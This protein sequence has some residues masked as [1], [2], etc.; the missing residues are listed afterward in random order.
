MSDHIFI[1]YSSADASDFAI[2]LTLELQSRT[3]MF[4][5]WLDK[6]E[7][8]PGRDWD[9]QIVEGIRDCRALAFI[10]TRDSVEDHSVCKQEWTRALK[11][12]KPIVP[13]RLQRD[14]EMPFRLEPRQFIDFS[15]DFDMALAKLQKYLGWLDSPEGELQ[16][17][18]DRLADANRDLRRASNEDRLRIQDEIDQLQKQIA[19]QQ[20]IVDNPQQA[21]Q[22]TT[23]NIQ[24]GLERERQ[25]EKPMGGAARSK[26]INPPPDVA[27]T[28]FQDRAVETELI[29]EF[30]KDESCCL[31]TINGR[32][33]VGK[34]AMACRLLKSLE[35]GHLPDDLGPLSVDGIVY[36]SAKGSRRINMPNLYVDLSKLLP[37]EKAQ[38]LEAL[39]KDPKA[40]TEAKMQALLAE[41][42]QGRIVVLL[43]NFEDL[44]DPAAQF[45]TDAE[46]NEALS[47]LLNAPQYAVKVIITTRISPRDLLLIRADRQRQ[48]HLDEGLESPHAENILRAMDADGKIKLKTASAEILNRARLYTRGYPRALVALYGILSADRYTSLEEVLSNPMPEDVVKALVGEAFNRLDPTAQK[49]MEAL[50]VY[51]R[52]ITSAA[53][54][55]LL[56]PYLSGINSAPVLNRLVNMQFVR[57]EGSRYYQHAVDRTYAL[58]RIPKGEVSDREDKGNPLW[59]Q[60]ALLHRGAEYFSRARLPPETWKK[61]DDLSPQLN[62]FE[63]RY[64]GEDYDTAANVLASGSYYLQLWGHYR[65]MIEL[66]ERLQG[67]LSDPQLQQQNRYALGRAHA[68]VGDYAQAITCYEQILTLAHERADRSWEH[69]VLTDLGWCYNELGQTAHAIEYS[70]QAL[71]TARELQDQAGEA[72]ALTM[73]GWYYGK[74]GEGQHALDYGEQAL[75]IYLATGDRENEG[76]ALS[77]LAGLLIDEGRY[78][79]A[80]Q[81]ARQSISVGDELQ[82]PLLGNW[83]NDFLAEAQLYAGD[84]AAARAAADTARQHDEPENN[85]H[86]FTL[87]GVIALRQG[88]VTTAKE[89]FATAVVQADAMLARAARNYGALEAKG[90][91]LCGL[92]L[93][94][95]RDPRDRLSEAIIALRAAR[96]INKDAG[97]VKRVLRLFDALIVV[98]TDGILKNVR[99]AAAGKE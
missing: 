24:T 5:V 16:A 56:Q 28:Y 34:T 62:E 61:L 23:Q 95:A 44:I 82:M 68:S 76:V 3:P 29:G 6:N 33:G 7:I 45:I 79:E 36:L 13:L 81:R 57:K 86:V 26:F 89:A 94:E 72:G 4:H 90:L 30:L 20:R 84:L 12:K 69:I 15:G 58:L 80:I 9:T 32:A 85:H 87:L 60:Y 67:K 91:A 51:E 93:C 39:Y 46:L 21:A 63:L 27:P 31:L 18:K 47:A 52:P 19:E 1:S 78:K 38:S 43:D 88:E 54:D 48:I 70:E 97:V 99:S 41:F 59:T 73:L 8:D 25:P 92:A 49:V 35:N 77:N 65:L 37:T 66:H 71:A 2:K 40:S 22:Q 11:Y 55:Y 74:Q 50:A 98:D 53:I 64:A 96:E 75:T 17:L 42:P 83:S 14:A 10:M